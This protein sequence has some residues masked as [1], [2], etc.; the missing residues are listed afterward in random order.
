M[1]ALF[2]GFVNGSHYGV[3]CTPR[4]KTEKLELLTNCKV[5][6]SIILLGKIEQAGDVNPKPSTSLSLGSYTRLPVILLD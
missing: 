5:N 4:V 3:L 6:K 2:L 1:L